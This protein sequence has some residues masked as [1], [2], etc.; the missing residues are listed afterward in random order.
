MNN[1]PDG[2]PARR[3]SRVLLILT[4]I[5]AVLYVAFI[6]SGS[7]GMT[8]SEPTV[9]RLLFVL[10]VV[11]YIVTWRNE[12]LGGAVFVVWWVGMWYLGLFVAEHDRGAGVV[13]GVPLFVLAILLIG[14]WYRRT[15]SPVGPRP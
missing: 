14:A 2:S 5:Y 11:G 8:G 4:S 9:V 13:M 7:Y 10:F 15:R 12:G 3:R 6:A 1:R